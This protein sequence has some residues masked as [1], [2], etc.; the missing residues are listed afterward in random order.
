MTSQIQ[1]F[2][3]ICH[4]SHILWEIIIGVIAK[5]QICSVHG[6]VHVGGT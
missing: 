5:Q 6:V 4:H 1:A 3:L 2:L